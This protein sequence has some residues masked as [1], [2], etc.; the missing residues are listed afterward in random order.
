MKNKIPILYAAV[1]LTLMCVTGYGQE[2]ATQ[3]KEGELWFEPFKVPAEGS[4]VEGELG[5]LMVRENRAKKDSNLIELVFPKLKSPG[6]K[7]GNP[8]VYLDGGPG[9][10]PIGLAYVP[11]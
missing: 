2:S 4:Q 6:E 8:V 3:R 1:F 9:S 7:P 5:H 11:E 10:S